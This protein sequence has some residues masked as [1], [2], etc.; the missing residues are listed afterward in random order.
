MARQNQPSSP[1]MRQLQDDMEK[2]QDNMIDKI[3]RP[4]M[5]D[6]FSC[7][8]KCCITA[9]SRDLNN[10]ANDCQKKMPMM[11]QIVQQ[12]MQTFQQ[13]LQRCQMNCNEEAQDKVSMADMSMLSDSARDQLQN[14]VMQCNNKC[15]SQF[16]EK[17][18]ALYS[19]IES[20]VDRHMK[21]Y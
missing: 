9:K 20:Q 13:R 21:Q 16:R 10:C 2:L 7:A 6:A 4:L 19:R 18:P 11:Q 14:Q 1:E 8:A 15:F 3:F 5:K 17:V 12:E